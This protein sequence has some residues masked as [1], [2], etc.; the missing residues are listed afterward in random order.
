M[1]RTSGTSDVRPAGPASHVAIASPADDDVRKMVRDAYDP[2]KTL[3]FVGMLGGPKDLFRP[4]VGLV[5]ALFQTLFSSPRW[6]RCL[7]V[8]RTAL[9]VSVMRPFQ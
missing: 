9:V 1:E 2:A 3:N 7:Q 6:T 8:S 5:K 4:A